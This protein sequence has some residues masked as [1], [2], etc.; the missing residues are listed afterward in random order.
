[1]R[2]NFAV[3]E[4]RGRNWAVAIEDHAN[5]LKMLLHPFHSL[6]SMQLDWD[7]QNK[8][9]VLRVEGIGVRGKQ[10]GAQPCLLLVRGRTSRSALTNRYQ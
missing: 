3:V 4:D 5:V 1:M 2:P 9:S 8:Q 7:W 6:H 10:G